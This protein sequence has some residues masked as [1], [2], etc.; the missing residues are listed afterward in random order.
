LP[1]KGPKQPGYKP[2]QAN[3]RPVPGQ[4]GHLWLGKTGQKLEDT[5]R[6]LYLQ[7]KMDT[8]NTPRGKPQGVFLFYVL[9]IIR[10][11]NK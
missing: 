2:L 5:I 4:L 10:I 3:L 7:L 8:K 11:Y 6:S 1:Q 9:V